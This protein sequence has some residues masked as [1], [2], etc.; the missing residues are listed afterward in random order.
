MLGHLLSPERVQ[1]RD[2]QLRQIE[3]VEQVAELDEAGAVS[4]EALGQRPARVAAPV[5]VEPIVLVPECGR[6]GYGHQRPAT[7]RQQLD[8]ARGFLAV[9]LDVLE[10]IE[11]QM[12]SKR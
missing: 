2:E 9:V 4:G 1:A 6:G 11:R 8:Q 12:R 7:G 5:G 10:H 3:P